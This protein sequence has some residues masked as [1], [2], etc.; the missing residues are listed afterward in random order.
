M[1]KAQVRCEAIRPNA[2]QC[3]NMSMPGYKFCRTHGWGR[4]SNVP[5]HQNA[6]MWGVAGIIATAI[7]GYLFFW[8]G[9]DPSEAHG[10][11]R[12][13]HETLQI[14][15]RMEAINAENGPELMRKFPL[16]YVL[17]TVTGRK[18]VIPLGSPMDKVIQFDW[19]KGDY[20][21][22]ITNNHIQLKLPPSRLMWKDRVLGLTYGNVVTFQRK[23]GLGVITDETPEFR[24][25]VE[26]VSVAASNT[27]VALGLKPKVP[28]P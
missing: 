15:R 12:N 17:F 8:K 27:I 4:I 3:K 25:A 23:V 21:V 1:K 10:T 9:P 11:H 14:L 20:G 22:E 19:T 7:F 18:E 16:G 26:V 13:S 2:K 24:V 28:T 6:I 5:W